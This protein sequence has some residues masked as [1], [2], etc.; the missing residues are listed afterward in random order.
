MSVHPRNPYAGELV[1][2]AFSGSHQDAI[3]KAMLKREN[4]S[5]DDLWDIPYLTIDP[6][7]IGREYEG[8]IRIN[9][10][11]K[12]GSVYVLEHEFGIRPPKEMFS[13]IGSVIKNYADKCN[14]ELSSQEVYKIFEDT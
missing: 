14:K 8:I 1:F 5:S 10:Q 7:D 6:H 2:T 12:G 11:R 13:V 3:R 9:S 4:S